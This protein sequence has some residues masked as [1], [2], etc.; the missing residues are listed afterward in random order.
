MARKSL[1]PKI[2]NAEYD[3]IRWQ[4]F[5]DRVAPNFSSFLVTAEWEDF[6]QRTERP[7]YPGRQKTLH[8]YLERYRWVFVVSAL[9]L[10]VSICL[11]TWLKVLKPAKEI[12]LENG[13]FGLVR[14]LLFGRKALVPK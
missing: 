12:I 6:K 10:L 1:D 13:V 14:L 5:E 7:D 9:Y 2:S 3:A 4:Y 8:D 11:W